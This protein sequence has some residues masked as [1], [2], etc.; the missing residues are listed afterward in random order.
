[1]KFRR[2]LSLMMTVCLAAFGCRKQKEQ[3]TILIAG[4]ST[5]QYYVNHLVTAFTAENRNVN[6]VCEDGGSAAAIVALKHGA[7]DIAM[8]SRPVTTDEDDNYLRDYLVARDSIAIIVNPKNPVTDLKT[9]QL[10]GIFQGKIT[11]WKD[12]GGPNQKIFLVDQ[13][14]KSNVRESL[15]TILLEGETFTHGLKTVAST[16]E[17]IAAVSST[18]TAVGYVTVQGVDSKVKVL[19]VDGVEMSKMT[20]L[21]G[22]YPLY[23]SFFLALHLKATPSADRFVAFV[24]SKRGQDLLAKDGLLEVF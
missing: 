5:M 10:R 13:G 14:R 11:N 16:E 24:R 21:S 3:D 8:L 20:T 9:E 6:I 4:A 22:R 12:L 15:E 23:R 1:M 19:K 7:V 18:S 2:L 17:M